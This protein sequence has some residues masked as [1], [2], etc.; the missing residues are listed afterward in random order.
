MTLFKYKTEAIRVAL[1]ALISALVCIPF[2]ASAQSLNYFDELLQQA[3]NIVRV[4]LIPL[5]IGLSVLL[6]IWGVIQYFIYGADDENS[7]TTGRAYMLYG[8]IGLTAI[9]AVW[10]FV[11]LLLTILG[12]S[13]TAAPTQPNY[14]P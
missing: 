11:N 8:L 7:R 5:V 10:G 1:L 4:I 12:V 14:L 13:V 6:F 2:L 3:D 9:V